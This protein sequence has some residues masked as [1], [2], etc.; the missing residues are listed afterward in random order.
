MGYYDLQKTNL[1]INAR[2]YWTTADLHFNLDARAIYVFNS[3]GKNP[4]FS[5]E[6]PEKLIL[7]WNNKAFARSCTY[8][9]NFLTTKK[10]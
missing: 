7:N 6:F 8:L 3:H 4:A 9:M 1:K 2:S 10:P 5:S